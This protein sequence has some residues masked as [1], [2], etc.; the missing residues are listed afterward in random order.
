[1]VALLVRQMS[2]AAGNRVAAAAVFVRNPW[3]TP[4]IA[5]IHCVQTS[6]TATSARRKAT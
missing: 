1:M 5:K 2:V 3:M 6:L 4:R